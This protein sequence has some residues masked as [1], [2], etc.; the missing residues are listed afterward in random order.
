MDAAVVMPD[1]V[2]LIFTSLIHQKEPRV[3]LLPEILDAIKGAS[4]HII[5]KK[6]RR[7][8]SVWQDE[9]FD[10][11]LRSSEQLRDR[12]HYILENPVRKGLVDR[13]QDYSWLWVRPFDNPCQPG[14]PRAAAP[15][16][17]KT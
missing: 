13:W 7:R 9:S 14:R 6:L 11:V 10:H 15:T 3:W 17:S 4:A 5:N 16:R 12:V 2:H 1:H 8:G